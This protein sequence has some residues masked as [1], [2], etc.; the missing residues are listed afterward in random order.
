M[1]ARE[2]HEAQRLSR[3]CKIVVFSLFILSLFTQ[4]SLAYTSYTRQ[5]LLDIGSCDFDNFIDGLRLIPKISKTA[6]ATNPA[7]PTGSAHRRRRDRKQ[8]QGKRGGLR[9]RLKQTPHRLS[10]PSIF[11]ANVRSLANKIDELRLRITTHDF[12]RNMAQQ[13]RS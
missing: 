13:R 1:A 6:V 11:L 2:Q 8:R 7:T 12:Y 9:A 10:L 5:Q 3:I 4:N